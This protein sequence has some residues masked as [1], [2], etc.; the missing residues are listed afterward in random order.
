MDWLILLVVIVVGGVIGSAI[1]SAVY[2][3]CQAIR[4]DWLEVYRA[5]PET[6]RIKAE[7]RTLQ[8]FP[9][10]QHVMPRPVRP[11]PLPAPVPPVAGPCHRCR[12]RGWIDNGHDQDNPYH[13]PTC[14]CCS[15]TGIEKWSVQEQPE[16]RPPP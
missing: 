5:I 13:R 10:R 8:G 2:L 15:G 4:S 3:G 9:G 11:R 6:E 14:W 12:V 7:T 16:K 1:Y